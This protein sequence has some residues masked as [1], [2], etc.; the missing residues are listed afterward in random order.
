[1]IGRVAWF[2]DVAGDR[3]SLIDRNM[4]ERMAPAIDQVEGVI[5]VLWLH[6]PESSVFLSFTLAKNEEVFDDI[7]AAFDAR[8]WISG[9]N[10]S[11]YP[12]W[13]WT[14]VMPAVEAALP[15]EYAVADGP[16]RVGIYR[17]HGGDTASSVLRQTVVPAAISSQ[18]FV[19]GYWLEDRD[20]DRRMAISRY[21]NLD[22]MKSAAARLG[23]GTGFTPVPE[24]SATFALLGQAGRGKHASRP[25]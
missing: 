17:P 18:G 11:D 25:S 22:A 7:R 14:A 8:P 5:R 19:E 10:P 20:A 9:S 2:D 24:F 1:V 13:S 15:N 21:A 3:L 16:V 4:R 6:E 12:A 23:S